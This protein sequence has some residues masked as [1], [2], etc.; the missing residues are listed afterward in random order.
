[1]SLENRAMKNLIEKKVVT[2][3]EKLEAVCFLVTNERLSNRKAC[4][5]IGMSRTSH[6][7]KAK[8]KDDT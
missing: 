5:L 2:P 3:Q 7:Y 4:K 8:P 1:M 6:Q